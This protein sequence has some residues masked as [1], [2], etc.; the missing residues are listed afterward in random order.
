MEIRKKFYRL[1]LDP[2]YESLLGE[3][4]LKKV[5]PIR[6]GRN[7]AVIIETAALDFRLRKMGLNTPMYFLK[8]SEELIQEKKKE[9]IL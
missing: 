8:M 2:E 3:K 1:G 7:L 6:K 5:L 4:I 9:N